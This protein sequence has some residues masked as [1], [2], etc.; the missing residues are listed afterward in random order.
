MH[1]PDRN[2][3][4][5]PGRYFLCVVVDEQMDLSMPLEARDGIDD[6]LFHD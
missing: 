3:A 2:F 4:Y 6:K 5:R 1:S